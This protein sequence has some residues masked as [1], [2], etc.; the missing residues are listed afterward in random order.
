MTAF[1]CAALLSACSLVSHWGAHSLALHSES[2]SYLVKDK[3]ALSFLVC[4]HS[5]THGRHKPDTLEQKEDRAIC[6]ANFNA[7]ILIAANSNSSCQ[8]FGCEQSTE[9]KCIKNIAKMFNTFKNGML[10]FNV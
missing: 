1:L 6:L 8:V 10:Y 7:S 9:K 4:A 3:A 5:H 2:L